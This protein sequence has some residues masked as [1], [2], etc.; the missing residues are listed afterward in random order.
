MQ[1]LLSATDAAIRDEARAFEDRPATIKGLTIEIVVGPSGTV[2]DVT[3]YL[4][5]RTH[6]GSLMARKLRAS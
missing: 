6:G 2:G 3:V 4:E 1:R 5:R